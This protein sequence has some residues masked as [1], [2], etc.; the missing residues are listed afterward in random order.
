MADEGE[1][2]DDDGTSFAE[3]IMFDANLQEFAQ[4]VGII[5]GLEAG[6]KISPDE[7]YQ[8]IKGLWKQ[9]KQSKRNLRI[10]EQGGGQSDARQED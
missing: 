6:E 9:L 10:G 8:R 1:R 3:E 5:V 4:R 2:L 7:A